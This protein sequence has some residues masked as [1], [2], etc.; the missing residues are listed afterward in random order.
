MKVQRTFQ[1]FSELDLY[2]GRTPEYQYLL[3]DGP[4]SLGNENN[5]NQSVTS[6]E[7]R[8]I[9]LIRKLE[10]YLQRLADDKIVIKE[11]RFLEFLSIPMEARFRLEQYTNDLESG[12]DRRQ[13]DATN[14]QSISD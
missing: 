14:K 1:E 10:S 3:T 12:I 13:T 9:A 4:S 8:F 6:R 5:F 2:L 7:T 11:T